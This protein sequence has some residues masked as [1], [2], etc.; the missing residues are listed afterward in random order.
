M[1]I[2]FSQGCFQKFKNI[3]ESGSFQLTYLIGCI[4]GMSL[5]QSA[6]SLSLLWFHRLT[7]KTIRQLNYWLPELLDLH[8]DV[9]KA[10]AHAEL[11][12]EADTAHDQDETKIKQSKSHA[13]HHYRGTTSDKDITKDA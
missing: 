7:L 13:T 2:I 3:Q 9:E 6:L 1:L 11:E 8:Q 5:V 10:R 4:Q 12:A